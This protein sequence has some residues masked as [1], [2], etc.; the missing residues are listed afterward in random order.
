MATSSSDGQKEKIG[1]VGTLFG[2]LP[3]EITLVIVIF[4]VS[5]PEGLPLTV[6]VSLASTVMKMFH[7]KILVRKLDAPEK[8]GG[9]DEICC[10]KTGTITKNEMRVS[11]FYVE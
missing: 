10:G 4:V 7:D 9:V 6:G 1:F 3:K 11:H 5:V 8:M 2:K